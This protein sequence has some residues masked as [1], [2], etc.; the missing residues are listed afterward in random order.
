[1]SDVI[2]IPQRELP[3][4]P[5]AGTCCCAA[6]EPGEPGPPGPLSAPDLSRLSYFLLPKVGCFAELPHVVMPLTAAT[7]VFDGY[8]SKLYLGYACPEGGFTVEAELATKL[9]GT[10]NEH[11][12][13]GEFTLSGEFDE[14]G[15]VPLQYLLMSRDARGEADVDPEAF[16]RQSYSCQKRQTVLQGDP[17]RLTLAELIAAVETLALAAAAGVE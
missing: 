5:E 4:S 3:V 2:E 9:D 10:L 13:A 16:R 15:R 14:H 6:G 7:Y 8:G 1:M 12:L 11:V 17:P